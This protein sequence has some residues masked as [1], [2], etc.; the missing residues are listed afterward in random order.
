MLLCSDE[1]QG[2]T[3]A[4]GMFLSESGGLCFSQMIKPL[5]HSYGLR[6]LTARDSTTVSC[7]V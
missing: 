7:P 5:S 1:G 3:E 2:C 6:R 4:W